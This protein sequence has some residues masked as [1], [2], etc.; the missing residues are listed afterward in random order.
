MIRGWYKIQYTSTLGVEVLKTLDILNI[1]I[2]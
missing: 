2:I 1:F